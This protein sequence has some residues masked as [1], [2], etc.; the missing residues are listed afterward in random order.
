MSEI[1]SSSLLT[2]T[3]V[4]LSVTFAV[5]R[6]TTTLTGSVLAKAEVG[7]RRQVSVARP[8]TDSRMSPMRQRSSALRPDVGHDQ[9]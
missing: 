3:G 7:H 6:R 4:M 9:P 8:S 1:A 5:P 2:S